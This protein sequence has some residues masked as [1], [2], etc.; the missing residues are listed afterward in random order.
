M[1]SIQSVQSSAVQSFSAIQ[2]SGLLVDSV[3][4]R[5]YKEG[6]FIVIAVEKI[7]L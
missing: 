1:S 7:K 5:P 6:Q 4:R 3:G 2:A